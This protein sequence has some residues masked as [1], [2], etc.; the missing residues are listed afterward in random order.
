M[1]SERIQRAERLTLERW[2]R[3]PFLLPRAIVIEWTGL[4]WREL[5]EEIRTGRLRVFTAK[6]KRKF[7]KTEVARLAGIPC[8]LRQIHAD[9]AQSRLIVTPPMDSGGL[10]CSH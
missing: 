2:E 8:A 4:S 1:A 7:F 5:Q 3:L 10:A 6:R 9:S